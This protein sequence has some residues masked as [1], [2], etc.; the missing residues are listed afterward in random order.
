MAHYLT[1][2]TADGGVLH[3][4]KSSGDFSYNPADYTTTDESTF[5]A[6][7]NKRVVQYIETY[8]VKKGVHA[9]KKFKV[10]YK[11]KY[12]DTKSG[13]KKGRPAPWKMKYKGKN[14]LTSTQVQQLH[15]GTLG[16]VVTTFKQEWWAVPP[17]GVAV[18]G[19]WL[20]EY[21]QYGGM[22]TPGQMTVTSGGVTKKY[23]L[24]GTGDLSSIFTQISDELENDVLSNNPATNVVIDV[25]SNE[26][27]MDLSS[28][29]LYN[30]LHPA[31]R[32][33]N[34]MNPNIT[35][36]YSGTDTW[37]LFDD[38]D[39]QD[40][41]GFSPM[42]KSVRTV[43][44]KSD[45]SL[46]RPDGPITSPEQTDGTTGIKYE[47]NGP[48]NGATILGFSS[49]LGAPW[50]E[51]GHISGDW[52]YDTGDFSTGYPE[53]KSKYDGLGDVYL[54]EHYEQHP[55][56]LCSL[57]AGYKIEN[58][59]FNDVKIMSS[60]QNMSMFASRLY[61]PAELNNVTVRGEMK[62]LSSGCHN[63]G[64]LFSYMYDGGQITARDV[65]INIQMRGGRFTNGIVGGGIL[66]QTTM[67]E[68]LFE[69]VK[70]YGYLNESMWSGAEFSAGGRGWHGH[71]NCGGFISIIKGNNT[72]TLKNVQM[73]ADVTH[74]HGI[75][76]GPAGYLFGKLQ[77][78]ADKP[79]IINLDN[80][81]L[82][83]RMLYSFG[84]G[85]THSTC[86]DTDSNNN[87]KG[88]TGINVYPQDPKNP[89]TSSNPKIFPPI[90]GQE[91]FDP[92]PPLPSGTEFR[93]C[94]F[95]GYMLLGDTPAYTTLN[96]KSLFYQG[97]QVFA[98]ELVASA[99]T[100]PYGNL[101]INGEGPLYNTESGAVAAGEDNTGVEQVTVSSPG[102]PRTYKYYK[103]TDPTSAATE[104]RFNIND[105]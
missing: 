104:N 88:K 77:G 86:V 31:Q 44:G 100:R 36:N 63:N 96:I 83:G 67:T 70:I 59:I 10:I 16:K 21:E 14:G 81:Q 90:R 37:S 32:A 40:F 35:F 84:G 3:K 6:D 62:A 28:K 4:V 45:S 19:W 103:P 38:L 95:L 97:L 8:K 49:V 25:A 7:I 99:I 54:A 2:T 66:E 43:V 76:G 1:E 13:K 47:I 79:V 12:K 60:A 58:M 87:P 56:G 5:Q 33:N 101:Y 102:S 51:T 39:T 89:I 71:G 74:F 30:N 98:N 22:L 105:V 18:K 78:T 53:L 93:D 80:V 61:G 42:G 65:N 27:V 75:Y 72:L 11:G 91:P 85:S 68:H 29:P 48:E 82:N 64:V 55:T 73:E 26:Y 94:S 15:G 52:T 34:S 41:Y 23:T 24:G 57:C 92:Q 9:G 20:T 50:Y 69:D 17:Q 46:H